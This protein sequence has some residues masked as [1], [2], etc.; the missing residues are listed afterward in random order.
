MKAVRIGKGMC[1][2]IV[3]SHEKQERLAK[4]P[5]VVVDGNRVIFPEWLTGNLKMILK[6]PAKKKKPKPEQ[7]KL[8]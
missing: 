5:D 6:P 2:I 4:I 8:F 3:R 7:T 1:R